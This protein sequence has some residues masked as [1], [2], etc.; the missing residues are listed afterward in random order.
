[1]VHLSQCW[2]HLSPVPVL[3][4]FTLHPAL[5]PD[6]SSVG[7]LCSTHRGAEVDLGTAHIHSVTGL[8]SLKCGRTMGGAHLSGALTRNICLWRTGLSN[9]SLLK[10]K[11]KGPKLTTRDETLLSSILWWTQTQELYHLLSFPLTFNP[12][13]RYPSSGCGHQT[14]LSMLRR[15][16][17]CPT[18]RSVM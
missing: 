13:S 12:L 10:P 16:P 18:W 8:C 6:C 5:H 9:P 14:A 4:I 17:S 7:L 11:W 2:G 15:S 3:H 1:M